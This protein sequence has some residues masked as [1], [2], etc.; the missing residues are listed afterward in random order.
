MQHL[1]QENRKTQSQLVTSPNIPNTHA[2][3]LPSKQ[4]S[5]SSNVVIPKQVGGT[6]RSRKNKK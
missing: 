6:R 3:P 5:S 4:T 1:E 2:L